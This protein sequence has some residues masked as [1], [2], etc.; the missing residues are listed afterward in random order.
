MA[1]SSDDDTPQQRPG[2]GQAADSAGT[3]GEKQTAKPPLVINS[4]YVKDLS[5]EAPATPG[6][7][8]Q[9]QEQ[10]PDIN[11]NV[12]VQATPLGNTVYEVVLHIRADCKLGETTA[13]L[14]EL[15]YGGVFTINVPPEHLRPVL[16]IECPRQ[17]FPFAR[18]IL[19]NTTREGGFLPLMLGPIDFAGMY[20]RQVQEQKAQA[21]A[22]EESAP[23]PH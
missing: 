21:A 5:F 4:Q 10:Q 11:I 7:F 23:P 22:A 8:A 19:A 1:D 6:I 14:T 18:H 3:G 16:L 12:N 15:A 2:D 9:M 20:Q 13:F 17:L